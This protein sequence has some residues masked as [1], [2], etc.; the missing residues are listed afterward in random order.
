MIIRINFYGSKGS[1]QIFELVLDDDDDF[2]SSLPIYVSK[3]WL[4][5]LQLQEHQSVAVF[6]RI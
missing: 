2:P 5:L 1:R 3:K 6:Y 4:P